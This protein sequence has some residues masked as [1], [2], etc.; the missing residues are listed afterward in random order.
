[1]VESPLRAIP[2]DINPTEKTPL[3]GLEQT[4]RGQTRYSHGLSS[5]EESSPGIDGKLLAERP[6][7]HLLSIPGNTS[8]RN[9]QY[10]LTSPHSPPCFGRS[11]A[12]GTVC[13]GKQT[14][15]VHSLLVS[16]SQTSVQLIISPEHHKKTTTKRSVEGIEVVIPVVLTEQMQLDDLQYKSSLTR[17][18]IHLSSQ[19][20]LSLAESTHVSGFSDQPDKK[21]KKSGLG[22]RFARVLNTSLSGQ[23]QPESEITFDSSSST[24]AEAWSLAW[25]SSAWER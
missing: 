23:S 13:I 24:S 7:Q 11:Q 9:A 2:I 19:H 4:P 18:S 25:T 12:P 10:Q 5:A 15:Q 17:A 22:Y 3:K 14:S 8:E 20:H 16:N 21:K 6:D 1:M